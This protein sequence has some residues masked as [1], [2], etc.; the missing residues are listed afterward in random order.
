M[1]ADNYLAGGYGTRIAIEAKAGGW[2]K[3][4][5]VASTWQPSRLKGI[6]VSPEYGTPFLAAT[7]VYDVRPIPRKW[8]SFDRTENV[9]GRFVKAG[10]ILL[11]CSGD[12]GRA[13]L[14]HSTID[15]ILISHDLLRIEAH[16]AEWAGWIYAYLRAP[17]VRAILK[18]AQYGHIIK[19]LEVSH[20]NAL[21]IINIGSTSR[22]SFTVAAN[23]ILEKRNDSHRL[24]LEAERLFEESFGSFSANDFGEQGFVSRASS[25]FRNRRRLDAWHYNPSVNATERHLNSSAVAWQSIET[26]GFKVWL[27]T[28]FRRIPAEDGIPLVESA[29]LFELSPDISK[30]IADG[31]FGDPFEGRVKAGWIL[32]ARS[33]QIYGVNG[34]AMLPGTF[35]EGK[36]I[37]DDVIRIAPHRPLCP[38]GYL[39]TTLTHPTLGRPRVKALPY[40]SSIPHIEVADV[41]TFMIPRLSEAEEGRIAE[42]A[43]NAARL[44]SEADEME[45]A[46][47][48]EAELEIARFFSERVS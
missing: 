46:L 11:T 14:A 25:A 20:I 15:G 3:F 38:V 47:A 12:V 17:T 45:S 19:H 18:S 22:K 4:S 36:I 30:S 1:E 27:P 7:Q 48:E 33:G 21:P 26:L 10:T 35:C 8:L 23:A 39:A 2:Q 16:D 6:Q 29:S 32:L 41:Q 40:G 13:T 42:A 44:R 28:R 34:N 37:S 24:T 5:A 31:K 43:E 9:E